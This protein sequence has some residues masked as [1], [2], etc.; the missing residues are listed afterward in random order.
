M[1]HLVSSLSLGDC[2]VHRL[3]KDCR[4]LC[5]EQAPKESDDTRCSVKTTVLLMMNTRVLKRLE[6][7]N[8]CI[9]IKKLCI[10]L[11]KKILPRFLSYFVVLL[12]YVR[13]IVKS[14]Y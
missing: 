9:K 14:D 7:Y 5:T 1:Q 10:K 2:S 4:N 3:R 6:E 13:E 12:W 11:V 8:K